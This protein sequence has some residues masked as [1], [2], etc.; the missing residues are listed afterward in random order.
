MLGSEVD[1]FILNLLSFS[2][3]LKFLKTWHLECFLH[4]SSEHCI[5]ILLLL[6]TVVTKLTQIY[7]ISVIQA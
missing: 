6:E 4:I 3:V 2:Y 1:S 5:N 7:I